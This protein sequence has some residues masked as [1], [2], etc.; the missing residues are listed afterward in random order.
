MAL[1]Q[2]L[3]SEAA[4]YRDEQQGWSLQDELLAVS[5]EVTDMWGRA[6]VSSIAAVNGQKAKLGK[7]VRIDHPERSK[8]VEKPEPEPTPIDPDGK[9][10]VTTDP[11]VLA[12]FFAGL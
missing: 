10:K 2:G 4:I 8:A 3:P 5:I 9:K 7:P 12:K 6:I 11:Q 1:I